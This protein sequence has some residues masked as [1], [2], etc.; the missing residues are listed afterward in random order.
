MMQSALVILGLV[1]RAWD[2]NGG[3]VALGWSG[4]DG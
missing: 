4:G 2:D 1:P 3:F